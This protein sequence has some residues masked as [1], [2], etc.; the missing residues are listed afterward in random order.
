MFFITENFRDEKYLAAEV[1]YAVIQKRRKDKK[2]AIVTLRY[3]NAASVPGLLTPYIYKD[4]TNDL[5]GFTE[6]VR[7]LPIEAGPIRW[8]SEVCAQ[9]A[10][11]LPGSADIRVGSQTAHAGGSAVRPPAS[12]VGAIRLRARSIEDAEPRSMAVRSSEALKTP[13]RSTIEILAAAAPSRRHALRMS[14]LR[15]LS[16]LVSHFRLRASF[17]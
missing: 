16:R 9:H 4:I 3:A 14:Q 17:G 7:A 8:K 2:F 10:S 15:N 5:E 6:L 12:T 13:T 11:L 1:D